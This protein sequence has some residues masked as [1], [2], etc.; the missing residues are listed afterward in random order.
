M[1]ATVPST[2]PKQLCRGVPFST[3]ASLYLCKY[4]SCKKLHSMDLLSD[5]DI[6]KS[7]RVF[8]KMSNKDH[9][10]F[11]Q[12]TNPCFCICMNEKVFAKVCVKL[13]CGRICFS[14]SMQHSRKVVNIQIT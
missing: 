3:N 12:V 14:G 2:K 11:A 4:G 1:R 6:D 10:G 5:S 9:L 13:Q 7:N 8:H